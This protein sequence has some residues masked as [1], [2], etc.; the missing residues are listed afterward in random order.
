MQGAFLT[1]TIGIEFF[2]LVGYLFYLLFRSYTT[3]D[4]RVS[5]IKW[6]AGLIGLI[7]LGMIVSVVLVASRM[8]H[9][10]TVVA[11]TLLIVDVIG[12]Y[13]LVD[14]V[15]RIS[16]QLDNDAPQLTSI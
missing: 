3:G 5:M 12:V 15:R 13:L 7:T 8:S 6:V 11:A 16:H 9:T 10:D 1:I 4:D 2:L 14:D